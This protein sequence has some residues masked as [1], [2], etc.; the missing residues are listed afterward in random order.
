MANWPSLFAPE[1]PPEKISSPSKK[2]ASPRRHE[3]RVALPS[4]C[5]KSAAP[6]PP[7]TPR[8]RGKIGESPVVSDS[9]GHYVYRINSKEQLSLDQVK[10]EST[11]PA[12]PA[13]R[14]GMERYTSS[15]KVDTNE[16]YFGPAAGL[17]RLRAARANPHMGVSHSSGRTQAQT[18]PET[19]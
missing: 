4:A 17:C 5:P 18:R 9:G 3:D 15:F 14:D 19:N 6:S 10:D 16:K 11:T 12:E 7:D 1:P 8:I 13:P 2:S